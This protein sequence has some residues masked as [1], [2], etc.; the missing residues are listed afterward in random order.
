MGFHSESRIGSVPTG[1]QKLKSIPGPFF[2]VI[3]FGFRVNPVGL[4]T[5]STSVL[6]TLQGS[7]GKRG[8][9]GKGWAEEKK[10]GQ[11][12]GPKWGKEQ[13]KEEGALQA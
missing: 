6:V 7:E 9:G 10:N 2:R 5:T 11:G 13:G 3:W 4:H 8:K 12:V 1:S